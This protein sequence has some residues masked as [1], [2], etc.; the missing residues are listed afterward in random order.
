MAEER[1]EQSHFQTNNYQ[2][3]DPTFIKL[4]LDT[5]PLLQRAESFLSAKRVVI[6]KDK[7]TGQFYEQETLIGRPYANEEGVASILAM[8][9]LRANN[10]SVQGN[11][12]KEEYFDFLA[13]TRH[14]LAKAIINNCYDWG[15]EDSKL[16]V[17]L[18]TVMGYIRT[19]ISRTIDNKERESLTSQFHSRE[20][21]NNSDKKE[22][23]LQKFTGRSNE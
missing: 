5:S 14:E 1:N 7:E 17:I 10:H 23:I 18:D 21:I 2:L 20:V 9:D 8:L 19:F 3:L 11:F 12:N 4:K 22:G 15:I 16:I 6:V 13:D